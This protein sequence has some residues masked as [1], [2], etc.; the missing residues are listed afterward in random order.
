MFFECGWCHQKGEE[1]ELRGHIDTCDK[2][3]NRKPVFECGWCHETV[4]TTDTDWY[5]TMSE[6][7]K[8]CPKSPLRRGTG[9]VLTPQS[10]VE[11]AE[12]ALN[13]L[14]QLARDE[15]KRRETTFEMCDYTFAKGLRAA[16]KEHKV[17]T[18]LHPGVFRGEVCKHCETSV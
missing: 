12:W 16:L 18:C 6:H 17:Q 1:V 11:A 14:E 3:P 13:G 5:K 9:M 15:A 4:T 7:T 2:N 10:L 8:T